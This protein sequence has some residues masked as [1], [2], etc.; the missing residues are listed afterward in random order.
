[1]L[2]RA[3]GFSPDL[4]VIPINWNSLGLYWK[5]AFKENFPE[6]CAL[7]PLSDDFPPDMVNPIRYR[8][9]SRARQLLYKFE[10]YSLYPIGL[11]SL[12]RDALKF[13]F[14]RSAQQEKK[15]NVTEADDRCDG[16]SRSRNRIFL[17]RAYPMHILETN[18]ICLFIRTI[19]HMGSRHRT[20]VLFYISPINHENLSQLE[21]FDREAFDASKK[22]IMKQTEGLHIYC[23]DLSEILTDEE[24]LDVV[25]HYCI[26]GRTK[27]ADRLAVKTME[28]LSENDI[29]RREDS[30]RDVVNHDTCPTI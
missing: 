22:I 26:D 20:R 18:E 17:E 28:I 21:Y 15:R 13:A 25:L 3:I 7:A 5:G 30:A 9:I 23:I 19:S 10:I 8:G 2:H 1:M 16:G 24:F 6:L 27:I 4:V 11:R 29:R 12:A 14:P